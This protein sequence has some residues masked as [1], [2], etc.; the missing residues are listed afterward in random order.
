[1]I[2]AIVSSP[3]QQLLPLPMLECVAFLEIVV[4]NSS[5]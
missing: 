4:L 1:M 3:G 2:D 5:A